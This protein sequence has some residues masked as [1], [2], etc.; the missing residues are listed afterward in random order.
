MHETAYT[1]G[2]KTKSRVYPAMVSYARKAIELSG[3]NMLA[4][5]VSDGVIVGALT[6]DNSSV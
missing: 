4:I 3:Q 6:S 2:Q 1:Y 5:P